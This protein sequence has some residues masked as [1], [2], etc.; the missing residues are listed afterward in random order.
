MTC[1]F[2]GAVQH[3]CGSPTPDEDMAQPQASLSYLEDPSLAFHTSG[4]LLC[5]LSNSSKAILRTAFSDAEKVLLTP[6]QKA[7]INIDNV[8]VQAIGEESQGPV[9]Y[10][11]APFDEDR[12]HISMESSKCWYAII[13]GR[14][15]TG[16]VQGS[17]RADGYTVGV[18]KSLALQ[19]S[20]RF[21]A[22]RAWLESYY[23]GHT[24]VI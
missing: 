12:I 9:T 18:S 20:T 15:F 21:D 14:G 23:M 17:Y 11:I 16:V 19:H 3:I 7:A 4:D 24:G 1:T 6:E 10:H 22:E 5:L 13:R 8:V 2:C